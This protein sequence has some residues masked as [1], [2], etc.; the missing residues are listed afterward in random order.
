[1]GKHKNIIGTIFI[2]PFSLTH[3]LFLGVF[4][5]C[6]HTPEENYIGNGN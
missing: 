3:D 2:I 1:M 5:T 4:A 6:H